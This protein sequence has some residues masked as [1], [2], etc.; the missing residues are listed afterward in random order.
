MIT[1]LGLTAAGFFISSLYGFLK[2]AVINQSLAAFY[3][4]LVLL[5]IAIL[6]LL[7]FLIVKNHQQCERKFKNDNHI[8]YDLLS[9]V[10]NNPTKSAMAIFVVGAIV[11][12]SDTLRKKMIKLIRYSVEEWGDSP[13]A[14]EVFADLLAFLVAKK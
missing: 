5:G 10:K 8:K 7:I 9:F 1:L 6:F 11:G 2:M 3:C 13:E 12:G 4:G 14:R